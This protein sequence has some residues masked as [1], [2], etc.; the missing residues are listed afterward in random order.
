MIF[1]NYREAFVGAVDEQ[2]YKAI[3]HEVGAKPYEIPSVNAAAVS[4]DPVVSQTLTT[5]F[6]FR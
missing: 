6:T 5:P 4:Q 2:S 3:R 1:P